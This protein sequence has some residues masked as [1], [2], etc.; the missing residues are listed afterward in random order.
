M[1]LFFFLIYTCLAYRNKKVSVEIWNKSIVDPD[2]PKWKME[3]MLLSLLANGKLFNKGDPEGSN[4]II[5]SSD[6]TTQLEL[7][8]MVVRN[9]V[10]SPTGALGLSCCATWDLCIIRVKVPHLFRLVFRVLTFRTLWDDTFNSR[11][12]YIC[13]CFSRYLALTNPCM[14]RLMAQP[15]TQDMDEGDLSQCQKN[16]CW[17]LATSYMFRQDHMTVWTW[18][19]P[20]GVRMDRIFILD[21]DSRA[22]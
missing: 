4:S 16:E 15:R 5:D 21:E 18:W 1:R 6:S 8:A 9:R 20:G 7:Q 12:R 14:C 11:H 22:S 3:K 17:F 19:D 10:F 2:A 13:N